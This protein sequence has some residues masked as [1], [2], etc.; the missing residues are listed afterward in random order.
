MRAAHDADARA[1]AIFASCSSAPPT[2]PAA[3]WTSTVCPGSTAAQRTSAYHAV[4]KTAGSPAAC[5]AVQPAGRAKTWWSGT[6]IRLAYPP[7]SVTAITA[8]PVAVR[9][10]TS[11]PGVIGQPTNSLA[12]E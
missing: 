6:T 3:E 1:P 5:S 7:K 11:K 8:S 12:D 9:P 10:A 4:R 2:P